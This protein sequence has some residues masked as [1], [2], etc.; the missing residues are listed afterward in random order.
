MYNITVLLVEDDEHIR[1]IVKRY[2]THQGLIVYEAE[3]GKMAFKQLE[4]RDYHLV[5]LDVMLPD[6]DGWTI[7]RR[8]RESKDIPVI[9]LT[10]RSE[11]DDKLFG[12]DLGAD[13]YITKPFSNKLL[14]ARIKAVLKRNNVVSVDHEM[15]IKEL[16]INKDARQVYVKEE[17]IELTPIE[18]SLLLYFVDNIDL[19]LSRTQILNSVWGYDYFGDERT[20][21]THVK[22]LRHKLGGG[23]EYIQTV[24]GHGYRM[25]KDEK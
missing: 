14:F 10:A 11:E 7:L 9:M 19:A 8:L 13:D 21:D 16:R 2:L 6:T 24:R 5:L 12:F 1:E 4:Q 20:V 17:I 23:N 3:N 15:T 25:M 22:R 18:Y